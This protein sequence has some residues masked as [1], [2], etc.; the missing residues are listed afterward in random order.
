MTH[1]QRAVSRLTLGLAAPALALALTLGTGVARAQTATPATEAAAP[2]TE[3]QAFAERAAAGNLFE[4]QT[5][6]LALERSKTREVRDF[7]DRML[8][9]HGM[10]DER[11]K[12]A[13]AADGI[14]VTP[15]LAKAQEEAFA[16]LKAA[17]DDQFDMA[18]L[19][20]QMTAHEEAVGLFDGF[21]KKGANGEL[22][23]FAE[24]TLPALVMHRKQVHVL[25][26]Q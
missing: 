13:L 11:M 25:A 19:S 10:A 26:G 18:Y 12:K 14:A 23:R 7:A 4:I 2:V 20:A 24:T 6:K 15:K 9:D 17:P 21:V 8:A 22:H 1:V 3:P 5:S 16:A